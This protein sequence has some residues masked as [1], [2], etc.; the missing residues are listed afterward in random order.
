VETLRHAG[1][2]EGSIEHALWIKPGSR[3]VKQR[4][5]RF[6]DEKRKAISE[7]ITKLLAARF[8]REVYHLE[9]LANPVLVKKKNGK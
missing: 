4:L 6:N 7:E 9:W 5:R 8:I 2:T 1:H 3:L